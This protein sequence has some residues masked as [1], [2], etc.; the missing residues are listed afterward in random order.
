VVTW[1][2]WLDIRRR[3]YGFARIERSR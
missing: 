2:T 1:A 3:Y